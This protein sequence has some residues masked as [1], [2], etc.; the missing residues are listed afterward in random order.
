MK[1]RIIMGVAA[2]VLMGVLNV[3]ADE[4]PDSTAVSLRADIKRLMELTEAG[5]L[6]IQAMNH[7]IAKFRQGHSHT[8]EKFW[9]YFK[10]KV[11]PNDIIELIIPI[12]EKHFTHEDIKQLIVFYESPIGK[13]LIKTQP[14]IF[15]ESLDV[16]AEWAQ[17]L[18]KQVIEKLREEGYYKK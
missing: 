11:D 17:K 10:A 1:T 16:G 3:S 14:Q 5:K 18:G 2:W 15:R 9:Q 12:Y 6:G 13:K 4:K 8:P 7:V